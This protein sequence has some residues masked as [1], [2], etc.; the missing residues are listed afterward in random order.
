MVTQN[1]VQNPGDSLE[2]RYQTFVSTSG[3]VKSFGWALGA[4]YRFKRGY[5]LRGNLAF[6]KLESDIDPSS[7]AETRFNSPD[8]RLN[9][10]IANLNAYK[11]LGFGVTWRWQ[12]DFLWESTFGVGDIP[13]FNTIDAYVSYKWE[14]R[15]SIIKIGGSNILNQGYTTGFGNPEIGGLYYVS[16]VFDQFMN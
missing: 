4:D 16:I 7:G 10:S 2:T 1:L 11:N 6:N 8:Y 12:N 5:T 14:K 15:K 9:M 13:S 3:S